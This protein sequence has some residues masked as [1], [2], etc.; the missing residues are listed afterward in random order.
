MIGP[1]MATLII[2]HSELVVVEVTGDEATTTPPP[3]RAR[4]S[5]E[6]WSDWAFF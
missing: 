4:G 1:K 5:D 2:L 6:G 3:K